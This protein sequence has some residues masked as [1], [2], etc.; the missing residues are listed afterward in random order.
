[1][2]RLPVIVGFGGVNPAGRLSLHHAYRR[3]VIDKLGAEIQDQTYRSLAQLMNLQSDPKDADARAYMRDH[4]LIR[5][6]EHFD[7][8]AIYWQ[9]SAVLT[10]DDNAMRFRVSKR[11]MPDHVPAN[12]HVTAAGDRDVVVTVDGGLEVLLPDLRTSRVTSAGQLPT[13]FDPAAL[14]QS[15]SHPRA[16]QLAIYGASDAIR[17]LGIDWSVLRST[18][19]PDQ[20][21]VYAGSAMG[22][23]DVNG[24]G[25]LLQAGLNGKRATS[26]QTPL[27]M[28][29]MAGD[30]VN[31]YVLGTVGH[32]GTAIGACATWLY[33][34]RLG[35]EDIMSG[36][37]RVAVIG[38]SEAPVTPEVIEGFR[39]MGAL[40]EDEALMAL[41]G[42]TDAPDNRRACRPFSDNCG[43][44]LGE[45]SVFAILMDDELA[46]ELGA[47]VL[48]AAVGVYV[49]ADGFKKS[50]PGPGIGNYLTM[51]K[52]MATAR[53]ILGEEA[54]RNRSYVQA[55]GT[56]TPQNRVTESH[57]LNEMAKTF[58]IE[59]WLIAAVKAYLGHSLG[60]ASGDQL[61]AVLGAWEFGVV[62]GITTIDHVA[63]D[64]HAS[65][66]RIENQHVEIDP[67][68]MDIALVNSKGFGGNNA[69]GLFLSP[70]VTRRMLERKHGKAALRRHADRNEPV[71]AALR[72]YDERVMHGDL[73]PIYQFGEG[74]LEGTD[75]E[76]TTAAL[77]IP[78]YDNPLDL[79]VTNPFDD[80]T[81]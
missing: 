75:L 64:V 73:R 6:I 74:V 37:A 16:L 12:W 31:A 59:R 9:R 35:V 20:F 23:L 76:I 72:E 22:Q 70:T 81:G 21:S 18:V 52:A 63:A 19:A 65:H 33:N 44:T 29:E 43:F 17:S 68:N 67:A 40:A 69:T 57:I 30:F 4:T 2:A 80:M 10:G 11:H 42:R 7:T 49:N 39:T 5:R 46:V 71:A 55:H 27:G 79:Q 48:G 45:S 15:R 8:N 62:P 78:G 28:S 1:V 24:F 41:D 77:Q 60:P 14:Y 61:S 32:T 3:M 58:G 38:N 66:L 51:A 25:G 54:V 36:R 47:N 53:A 56:G 34:L 50:I 26:K 13:G